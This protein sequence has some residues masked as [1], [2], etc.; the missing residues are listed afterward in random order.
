MQVRVFNLF[1]EAIR[2]ERA[3]CSD[4]PP[5]QPKLKIH[6]LAPRIK[7]EWEALT[8]EQRKEVTASKREELE[9]HREVRASAPINTAL[10]IFHDAAQNIQNIIQIVR[11]YF[12]K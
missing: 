2:A 4:L 7:A 9:G 12:H 3:C 5:G 6:E 10:S 1:I 8:P 11:L